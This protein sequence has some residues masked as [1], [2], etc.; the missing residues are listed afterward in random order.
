MRRTNGPP[1]RL[2]DLAEKGLDVWCWCNRCA[3][4]GALPVAKLIALLGRKYP[5]PAVSKRTYCARCRS[6]DV[7]TRPNWIAVAGPVAKHTPAASRAVR[8]AVA[9]ERVEDE[10]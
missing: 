4:N 9:A 8:S 6:R 5:V 3:H 7:E 10:Q 1:C 2:G